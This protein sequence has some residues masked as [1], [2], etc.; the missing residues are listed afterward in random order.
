MKPA[1]LVAFPV[2]LAAGALATRIPLGLRLALGLGLLAG[3]ALLLRGAL[4]PEAGIAE[5]L[6][7]LATLGAG[8]G[9]ANPAIAYAVQSTGPAAHAGAASGLNYTF[10]QLGLAVDTGG[11]HLAARRAARRSSAGVVYAE[12]LQPVLG[13]CAVAPLAGA[14]TALALAPR[15]RG[16][17]ASR[18]GRPAPGSGA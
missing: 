2:S 13:I 10:R 14:L 15:I 1:A 3:G 16:S 17:G 12:A 6:P 18:A 7:G 9:V 8:A 4:D 5:L 11:A